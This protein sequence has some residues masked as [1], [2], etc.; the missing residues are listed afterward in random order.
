MNPPKK[1]IVE[2]A[3][4]KEFANKLIVLGHDLRV[5]TY[6]QVVGE[7]DASTVSFGHQEVA[8]SRKRDIFHLNHVI[9]LDN[10][11]PRCA[12]WATNPLTADWLAVG[13]MNGRI[14]LIHL[15]DMTAIEQNRPSIGEF[16]KSTKRSSSIIL[17][18]N[19]QSFVLE[20]LGPKY[21]RMCNALAFQHSKSMTSLIAQA[22]DKAKNDFGLY[23][24]D[25]SRA[26]LS[27][28]GT[29]LARTSI[30]LTH[31]IILFPPPRSRCV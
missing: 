2:W 31:E 20:W 19:A 12:A 25:P 18:K 22:L 21:Q 16:E 30:N 11:I 10:Q 17:D 9:S 23:I 24:W 29:M 13:Y 8:N 26:S 6:E 15:P 3:P 28:K 14:A 1:R 7:F 5:Y 27:G 4:H